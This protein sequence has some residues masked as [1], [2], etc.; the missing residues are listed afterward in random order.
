MKNKISANE[1]TN[2][3]D[4]VFD[5]VNDSQ[6][7]PI[8]KAGSGGQ[9]ELTITGFHTYLHI[10][11]SLLERRVVSRIDDPKEPWQRDD[12]DD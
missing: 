4:T 8:V 1:L 3:I 7:G 2:L 11:D 5:A 10:L 6:A 9:Q 12:D